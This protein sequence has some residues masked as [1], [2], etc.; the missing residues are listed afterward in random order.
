MTDS[1]QYVT[2]TNQYQP[3][4]EF[5]GNEV[6]GVAA[7]GFTAWE[8]GT[9]GYD[10]RVLTE[11][12]LKDF[13][14]W[15]T[16]EAGVYNYQANRITLDGFVFRIDPN[17][18]VSVY[19]P[20]AYKNNDYRIIDLTIRNSNIHAGSIFDGGDATDPIRNFLFVN[21]RATTRNHAFNFFT[22][23]TP[24]TGAG[25]PPFGVTMTLRNNVITP[26][27]GQPLRT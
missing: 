17:P 21:N 5:R 13:R 16:Y 11:T 4:L 27:P 19:W 9:D 14:V 23:S 6:Y 26:W 25:R 8:L 10:E 7:D 22:P 20:S 12:V 15:H 1:A 2:V 3:L 18:A 24:G